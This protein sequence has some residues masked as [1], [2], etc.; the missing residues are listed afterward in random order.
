MSKKYK[1]KPIIRN[2]RL[3]A[4]VNI[5]IPV[6]QRFDLLEKCLESIPEAAM[7]TPYTVVMVDNGSPR[8]EANLFYAKHCGG[9]ITVVR[10]K[11]NMGFPAACNQGF[12]RWSA[13][14]AY[15]L[16]SD[17]VLST[18]AISYLVNAMDDP[19]V[20]IAASKLT[21][22]DDTPHG[23]PGSVQH[24]GLYT[25]IRGDF[26]HLFIGWSAD[27]PKVM[28]VKDVL[29]VTGAA[30][31]I[32]SKLFSQVGCFDE[33]YSPGT[34]EDID[35][36]MRIGQLNKRVVIVQ[37]SRGTHYVGATSTKYGM[38]FPLQRNRSL[39][40]ARWSGMY[41]WTAPIHL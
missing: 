4:L 18:G 19:N 3:T 32:R 23:P 27:H 15:F 5:V 33:A 1:N 20:G 14:L 13:P 30:L 35:L 41:P 11:E 26:E 37:E 28:A 6:H 34:Y 8:D 25:N 16:N 31:M 9:R 40:Q 39:F 7:D 29:A 2:E 22:P 12:R 36:C 38:H 10:N 21:F 24:V 17:V